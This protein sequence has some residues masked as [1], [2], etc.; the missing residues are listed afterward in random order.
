M[1]VVIFN[2]GDEKFAL[3]TNLVHGIEKVMTIT[4]IPTAPY[5]VKGLVNLRGNIVTILDLKKILNVFSYT[6]NEENIIIVEINEE[7]VGF[8][9]DRVE[10]VIEVEMD[11]IE[12]PVDNQEFIRGIINLNNNIITLLEGE[13]LIVR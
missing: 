13:T 8:M 9:V 1:Q 12:R 6:D 4:K 2:I 3:D 7:K 5:Y 11:S 10:E